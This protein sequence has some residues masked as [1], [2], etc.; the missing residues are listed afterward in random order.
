MTEEEWL[1]STDP[2]PMSNIVCNTT[3]MRQ[4]RHFVCACARDYWQQ[5]NDPRSQNSLLEVEAFLADANEPNL[6]R[7]VRAEA[8]GALADLDGTSKS[9][10]STSRR[11]GMSGQRVGFLLVE[12]ATRP[13]VDWGDVYFLLEDTRGAACLVF[14]E[15]IRDIFGNPFRPVDFDPRWRTSDV[16][17]L[18][19]AIYED[20]AFD[21]MPILA[22]ALMDAGC[23]DDQ[24]IGHCRGDGP[25]VRGCWVVDL[26]M[27]K[28]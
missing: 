10:R 25:H 12:L 15:R 7:N 22:D 20:R 21:R 14:A 5:L 28:E 4:I 8:R 9:T 17:G 24:I 6:L 19:R 2:W 1:I 26:V 11:L 13:Q 23:A 18:A 27:G 3:S 16:V